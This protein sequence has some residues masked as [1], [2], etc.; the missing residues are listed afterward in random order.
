MGDWRRSL[1]QTVILLALAIVL[2]D[3]TGKIPIVRNQE[4]STNKVTQG[5]TVYR[6]SSGVPHIYGDTKKDIL[7]AVGYTMAEDRLFQLEMVRRAG[8]GELAAIFGSELVSV[9]KKARTDGYTEAER[10]DMIDAMDPEMRELFQS[11]VAGINFYVEEARINPKAKLPFEFDFLDVPLRHYRDTDIVAALSVITRLY[12][13]AGGNE[14]LN[15]KF[16]DDLV[17]R[18]GED[19]AKI[20]FD[21]V[22]V[23]SDPDAYTTMSDQF[24]ANKTSLK[25]KFNT[26]VVS[27][28]NI[29]PIL[30]QSRQSEKKYYGMLEKSGLTRG[31]SRSLTIA[32]GRSENG[33]VLMMQATADGHEVHINGAGI[34][35]AG[36][37]IAPFGLPV[38]GRTS[39]FGWLI[40]TGERDTIDTFTETL[41]PQNKYQY[42]FR[43]EWHDMIVRTE[44]IE[45]EDEDPLTFE[46]ARTIH[47]PVIGW[48]LENNRAYS[49]R[50][51]FWMGETDAWALFARTMS[52]KT[53]EEFEENLLN[54]KIQAN[55][56]VSFGDSKGNIA[57]WHTGNLPNRAPGTDPRLP[58]PGTGEYEWQHPVPVKQRPYLKNPKK[59]YLFAWNSK[60]TS[61]ATYGDASRWGKH[62]RTYLPVSLVEADSSITIDDMKQFNRTIAAAFGSVDLTITS[63]RFFEQFWHSAVKGT[64]EK[65]LRQAVAQM[66]DWNE[67]YED[68]DRDGFY[69]HVGLTIFRKW[70]PVAE[71]FI[72]ED[73]IDKWWHELDADVYIKYRTSLLLRVL[74][75][76]Q[77]GLPVK[78]DFLNGK[79]RD[80]VILETL[81]L[82]ISELKKTFK[83]KNMEQWKLP[84]FW[85]YLSQGGS[86]DPD[87]SMP[88]PDGPSYLKESPVAGAAVGLGY[89]PDAVQHNGMPDW[90]TIME[91][92]SSPPRLLSAIPSGGQSWF[93]NSGWKASPHINDQYLRHHDFDYKVIE[94]DK[95]AVLADLE[96]TTIIRPSP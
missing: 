88:I 49:Q 81:R 1:R 95:Q 22:L 17:K 42:W 65:D 74:E 43:D 52:I 27:G 63:P 78:W 12:S 61:D 71:Q 7:F 44:T 80:S 59:N 70:L 21:D 16:Y 75:G 72:F 86:D 62:F 9:D 24:T 60:P 28:G 19:N 90:T 33:N 51:A 41:N 35:V 47:G 29:D 73:D 34:D 13:T 64:N 84:V 93:I 50:W 79:S 23:I 85:R 32:P 15:Q 69:D 8:M 45:V 91:F 40:T 56:N 20:I 82:T 57:V 67:L 5:V 2:G 31:A 36:L 54:G 6:D 46:V 25:P 48:D 66:V 92:G 83:S 14:L 55:N 68:Q 76:D 11:M 10:R 26:T 4:I 39:N 53:M 89:L 18:Y 58:T 77:A 94:M 38:M 3:C 96:S 30:K 87:R 37:S